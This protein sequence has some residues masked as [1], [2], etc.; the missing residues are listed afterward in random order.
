MTGAHG[1]PPVRKRVAHSYV[2]GLQW[3]LHYY[4]DGVVSWSWF[5][6]Y[7]YAPM[8]SDLVQLP[9]VQIHFEPG[10]STDAVSSAR[11][12]AA[13]CRRRANRVHC[14]GG[15]MGVGGS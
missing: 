12:H 5:F 7:H 4:Y 8:I 10:A 6:P 14:A 9:E 11:G 15:G 3:V 1:G 13:H 2:E